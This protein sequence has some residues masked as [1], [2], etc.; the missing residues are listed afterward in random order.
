MA[1]KTTIANDHIRLGAWMKEH[2]PAL[3]MSHLQKL[4]RTG[5]IRALGRRVTPATPLERGDEVKLP[6]FITEYEGEGAR[7]APK[8]EYS[9]AD[10][11]AFLGS[12]IYEDDEV[13][14]IDKPAGL[15]TQGGTGISKHVDELANAAMPQ[16][17]GSLRLVHRL[18][19][20]TSG[21]LAIAKG[22]D[23]AFKLASMFKEHRVEKTYLALVYGSLEKKS[24][25][26]DVPITDED[27]EKATRA[28]TLYKVL[29]EAHGTLSL[30]ELKPLSGRT[31]QI[32]AHMA[33][34]GHPVAGDFKYG[35]RG[36]FAKLKNVL[37]IE[38]PRQL[39]LHSWKIKI[40]GKRAA[41]APPPKHMIE[42][43]K[44]LGLGKR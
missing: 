26:I 8:H 24:G 22:Y 29:D 13:I 7:G 19:K 43:C 6:P 4:C 17:E 14:V 40:E 1:L 5:Q 27:G 33:H 15:A 32:R 39:Q 2:Y 20:D 23:A 12:I 28:T 18:D 10:I 30:V 31:H 11:G 3:T 34:I 25:S 21:A 35:E 9:R 36:R 16:Y 41:E 42:I 37:G 44:Y 38:L